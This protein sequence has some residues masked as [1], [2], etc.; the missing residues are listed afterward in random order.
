VVKQ[1]DKLILA[2]SKS[3]LPSKKIKLII[4]G[5]G[6]NQSKYEA[7]ALQLGIQEFVVF[8]GFVDN[9]FPYYKQALFM[10]LSSKNEGFPNVILESFSVATPVVC[11]DCFSGPNEIIINQ[12]NGLLVS[13]QNFDKLTEAMNVFINDSQLYAY[14]KQNTEAS[15]KPYDIEKIGK[16]WIELVKKK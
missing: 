7:L 15:S 6:Q 13:N 9:P 8:K 2:Y 12:Q 4:L 14:C 16:Q 1:F 10:V 5:S 11:F 3:V